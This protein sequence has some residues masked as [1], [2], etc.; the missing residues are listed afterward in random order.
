MKRNSLQK[1]RT[2]PQQNYCTIAE[3]TV[4]YRYPI[5]GT[6]TCDCRKLHKSLFARCGRRPNRFPLASCC[7]DG[8]IGSVLAALCAAVT[9]DSAI[10]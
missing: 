4:I 9:N 1:N 10:H 3:D 6:L 8:W 7:V 5:D 2:Q